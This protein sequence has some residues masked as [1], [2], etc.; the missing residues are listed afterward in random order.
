MRRKTRPRD[1]KPI[2]FFSIEAGVLV[3]GSLLQ[4]YGF[5]IA[6]P[7]TGVQDDC[8]SSRNDEASKLPNQ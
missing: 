3:N 8:P 4:G 2:L 5:L 1:V 7:D 6:P